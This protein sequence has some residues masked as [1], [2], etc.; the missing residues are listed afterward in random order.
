M[1]EY[2]TT[3]GVPS[4]H[5]RRLH[6]G[7]QRQRERLRSFAV[8]SDGPHRYS[9]DRLPGTGFQTLRMSHPSRVGT[10]APT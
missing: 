5:L 4:P 9:S 2:Y 8:Q 1:A 6:D 10:S 3:A 7:P